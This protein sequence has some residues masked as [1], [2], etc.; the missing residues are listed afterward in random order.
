MDYVDIKKL[1]NV[2]KKNFDYENLMKSHIEI[3]TGD[4]KV[5]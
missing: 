5:E 3:R 4:L 2:L 1:E